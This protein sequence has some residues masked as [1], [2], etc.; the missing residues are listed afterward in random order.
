MSNTP[1][2]CMSQSQ[3]RHLSPHMLTYIECDVRLCI[4]LCKPTDCLNC[5]RYCVCVIFRSSTKAYC[6]DVWLHVIINAFYY[7]YYYYGSPGISRTKSGAK[8]TTWGL[9]TDGQ[10]SVFPTCYIYNKRH[11]SR[12]WPIHT[13]TSIDFG[14]HED[15]INAVPFGD[16]HN[17]SYVCQVRQKVIP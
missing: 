16:Y 13:D 1:I 5:V 17:E 11:F 9:W 14:R 10:N 8:P 4:R 2:S 15:S 7:Y 3:R 6:T 12:D